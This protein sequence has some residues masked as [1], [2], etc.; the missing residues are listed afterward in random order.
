MGLND[1]VEC[2]DEITFF[3]EGSQTLM[4]YR[5]DICLRGVKVLLT[6]FIIGSLKKLE[7]D[8]REGV[9]QKNTEKWGTVI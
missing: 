4:E 9:V 1:N 6:P 3:S 8:C 5:A 2:Y 7:K